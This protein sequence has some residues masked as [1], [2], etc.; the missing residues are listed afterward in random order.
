MVKVM[1]S[2]EA[3]LPQ[4]EEAQDTGAAHVSHSASNADTAAASSPEEHQVLMS[5]VA[6]ESGFIQEVED[7]VEVVHGGGGEEVVQEVED[8]VDYSTI[9]RYAEALQS[10]A[11]SPSIVTTSAYMEGIQQAAW[12]V[13]SPVHPTLTVFQHI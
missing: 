6:A 3:S 1:A 13:Q 4:C 8:D 10:G 11:A 9:Q 5:G 12:H 7:D 2:V